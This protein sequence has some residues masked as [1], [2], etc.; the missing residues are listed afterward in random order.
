MID[1]IIAA[2][3]NIRGAVDSDQ[4]LEIFERYP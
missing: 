2:H 1:G 3:R 4:A